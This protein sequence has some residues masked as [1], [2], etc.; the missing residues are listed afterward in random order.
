MLP[1]CFSSAF[2][3]CFGVMSMTQTFIFYNGASRTDTI[4]LDW[5]TRTAAKLKYFECAQHQ[6]D[7]VTGHSG[8]A[9]VDFV[10]IFL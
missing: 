5:E 1:R 2:V 3:T 9:I 4:V 7:G 10:G 6:L 8:T